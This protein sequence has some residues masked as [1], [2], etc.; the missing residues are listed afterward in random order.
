MSSVSK[1]IIAYNTSTNNAQIQILDY[2]LCCSL[3]VGAT[4]WVMYVFYGTLQ[5][6]TRK[7]S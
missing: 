1:L 2:Q 7:K 5:A 6:Q 3:L 4:L